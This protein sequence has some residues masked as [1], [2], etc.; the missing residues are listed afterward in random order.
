MHWWVLWLC[1]LL[2]M[3][4]REYLLV[5]LVHIA[6]L[7]LFIFYW[8]VIICLHL[9]FII[10]Y[11]LGY[12]GSYDYSF[13]FCVCPIY[14]PFAYCFPIFPCFSIYYLPIQFQFHYIF[15]VN[16]DKNYYCLLSL[17]L[18]VHG[19][20]A[21]HVVKVDSSCFPLAWLT[22]TLHSLRF[23]MIHSLQVLYDYVLHFTACAISPAVL[24]PF[25]A[26]YFPYLLSIPYFASV[27]FSYPPLASLL[28]RYSIHYI[29]VV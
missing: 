14:V 23:L 18:F 28:C 21:Q 2:L 26:P 5:D 15:S 4:N 16:F 1:C 11:L 3:L 17:P 20:V 6:L 9:L 13:C 7:L 22:V 10:I 25:H 19:A 27:T 12:I 24:L 8:F 29:T